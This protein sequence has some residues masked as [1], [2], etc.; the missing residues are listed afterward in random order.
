M[1]QNRLH[2]W[3]ENWKLRDGDEG[4]IFEVTD[5]PDLESTGFEIFLELSL[6][7]ENSRC[8]FLAYDIYCQPKWTFNYAS[9]F[10][11]L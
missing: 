5:F 3:Y 8:Q 10:F 2:Y 4:S 1:I 6:L 11:E 7:K 9:L